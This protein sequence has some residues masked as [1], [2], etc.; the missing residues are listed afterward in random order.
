LGE[1]ILLGRE[2][3]HRQPID[4]LHTNAI[5]LVAEVIES[6]LKPTL[7]TGDVAQNALLRAMTSPFVS[8]NFSH[9]KNAPVTLPVSSDAD[10][11]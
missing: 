2:T 1:A 6:R 5:T 3:L 9:L 11:Q 10:L 8:K 4:G 7:P